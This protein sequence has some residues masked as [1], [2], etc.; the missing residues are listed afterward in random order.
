MLNPSRLGENSQK[1]DKERGKY[2]SKF[3]LF[4]FHKF[5]A[6]KSYQLSICWEIVKLGIDIYLRFI[7]I[8]SYSWPRGLYHLRH[9]ILSMA[10]ILYWVLKVSGAWRASLRVTNSF[11]SSWNS[12]SVKAR[13]SAILGS[14]YR[15]VALPR[16]YSTKEL[17]SVYPGTR[18]HTWI[19]IN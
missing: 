5:F 15:S 11:I 13:L 7:G 16:R 4:V 8:L 17:G 6:R 3:P 1:I 18:L 14:F 9:G 12:D 19:Y 2:S 10:W